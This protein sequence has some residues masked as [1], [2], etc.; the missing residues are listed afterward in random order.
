MI[1]SNYEIAPYLISYHHP[2]H[3]LLAVAVTIT[4]ARV[5]DM[6]GSN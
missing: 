6:K 3:L 1:M 2:S 5:A 4:V